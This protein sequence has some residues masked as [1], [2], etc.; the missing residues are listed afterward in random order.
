MRVNI[1]AIDFFKM[2]HNLMGAIATILLNSNGAGMCGRDVNN[3]KK[4]I[5]VQAIGAIVSRSRAAHEGLANGQELPRIA[6]PFTY[7]VRTFQPGFIAPDNQRGMQK[8]I[9]VH[10]MPLLNLPWYSREI[11]PEWLPLSGTVGELNNR[12]ICRLAMNLR[13][14]KT[15]NFGKPG[16]IFD[17]R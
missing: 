8:D 13:Q 15:I 11:P 7:L 14:V 10:A 17:G 2:Q 9:S 3:A 1:G 5:V 6:E 12:G 16:V 4:R